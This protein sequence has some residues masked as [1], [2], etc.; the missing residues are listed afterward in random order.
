MAQPVK[1]PT[2][3]QVSISW[4]VGSSSVSGSVLTARSLQPAS[5]SVSPSLFAPPPLVLSLSL[6]QR[7]VKTI[8]IINKSNVSQGWSHSN[9][10]AKSPL[11][12]CSCDSCHQILVTR[13]LWEQD[14]MIGNDS[15]K[16]GCKADQAREVS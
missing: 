7:N 9:L 16:G 14:A 1:R 4:F 2:S 12:I 3:A 11:Q 10:A 15:G 8:I 5:D 6:S 13:E